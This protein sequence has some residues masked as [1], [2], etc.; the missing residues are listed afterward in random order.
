MLP[1]WGLFLTAELV[2]YMNRLQVLH[3]LRKTI[4]K[5]LKKAW[6]KRSDTHNEWLEEG[7]VGPAPPEPGPQPKWEVLYDSGSTVGLGLQMKDN[8]GRAFLIKHEGK[9]WLINLLAIV[10]F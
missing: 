3:F 9:T 2:V 6:Q 4:L 7:K 1:L 8:E 5:R 10:G